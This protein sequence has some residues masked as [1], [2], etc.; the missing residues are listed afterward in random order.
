[1]MSAC[2]V[3][4]HTAWQRETVL[5]I[6]CMSLCNL[7][8][9]FGVDKGAKRWHVRMYRFAPGNCPVQLPGR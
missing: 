4:S 6:P 8:P 5:R 1:M 9:M 3:P 7:Q 2:K